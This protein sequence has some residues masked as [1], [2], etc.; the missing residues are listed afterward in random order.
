M[1]EEPRYIS[2]HR[3]LSFSFHWQPILATYFSEAS[4]D[5]RQR[6]LACLHLVELT[7]PPNGI[8]RHIG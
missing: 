4:I 7:R 2:H 5:I 8:S 6:Q 3:C 1:I